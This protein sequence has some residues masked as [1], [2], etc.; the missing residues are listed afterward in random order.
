MVDIGSQAWHHNCACKSSSDALWNVNLRT[1]CKFPPRK[2]AICWVHP[3]C[4][5]LLS[6]SP[7]DENVSSLVIFLVR[8]DSQPEERELFCFVSKCSSRWNS[9]GITLQYFKVYRDRGRRECCTK[10]ALRQ[11]YIR[12]NS[13]MWQCS[14]CMRFLWV[15]MVS[16]S[17]TTALHSRC[18]SY[19]QRILRRKAALEFHI[20]ICSSDAR[21]WMCVCESEFRCWDWWR[22]SR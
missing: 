20:G 10:Q 19:A 6:G 13:Q 17:W 9:A 14:C 7:L 15:S 4:G 2:H 16:I 1:K 22:A 18:L 8:S 3:A 5:I 11:G 21:H 12:Y